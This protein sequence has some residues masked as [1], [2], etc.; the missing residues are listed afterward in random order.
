MNRSWIPCGTRGPG[1]QVESQVQAGLEPLWVFETIDGMI[2]RPVIPR[3]GDPLDADEL[4]RLRHAM[5]RSMTAVGVAANPR[6]VEDNSWYPAA[7][8]ALHAHMQAGSL[9]AFVIDAEA[10][11]VRAQDVRPLAGCAI[12]ALEERLPGPGFPLGCSGWISSV[13]VEPAERG[14]GLARTMT[15]AAMEWLDGQGAEVIDLQATPVAEHLYRSL[16]FREPASL[17]L[18]SVRSTTRGA[19]K[20]QRQTK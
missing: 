20:R 3:R 13:F 8:K 16:G 4:I 9:A 5:F 12:A 6:A 11:P 1:Q 14:R 18:R 15:M 7:K 19:A 10:R 2:G 17:S